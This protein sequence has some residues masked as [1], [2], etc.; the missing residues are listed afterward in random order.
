M[1]QRH[2][3]KSTHKSRQTDLGNKPIQD[4]P[5][6]PLLEES[7]QYLTHS[8]S[9]YLRQLKPEQSQS[10]VYDQQYQ[11]QERKYHGSSDDSRVTPEML[12]V[13]ADIPIFASSHQHGSFARSSNRSPTPT[14][15]SAIIL[16]TPVATDDK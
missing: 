3:H 8:H 1:E 13:S 10:Q 4:I 11:Q 15:A 2:S 7:H 6:A 14:Q 16:P 12:I 5:D 9:K